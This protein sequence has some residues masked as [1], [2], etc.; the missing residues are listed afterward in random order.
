MHALQEI[1]GHEVLNML[2]GA[3]YRR[4]TTVIILNLS[5]WER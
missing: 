4:F 2:G 3:G 1:C 5:G